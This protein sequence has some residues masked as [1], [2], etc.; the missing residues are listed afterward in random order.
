MFVCPPV[1]QPKLSCI[2]VHYCTSLCTIERLNVIKSRLFCKH[3]WAWRVKDAQSCNIHIL[4]KFHLLVSC[5][6][7]GLF[8][9]QWG[10]IQ[11]QYP[12]PLSD[13]YLISSL[14]LL[15][16]LPFDT[17]LTYHFL[18]PHCKILFLPDT[19]RE[20]PWKRKKF[21]Q[22]LWLQYVKKISAASWNIMTSHK[23]MISGQ[24]SGWWL[25]NCT[26]RTLTS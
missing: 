17:R 12:G 24:H 16:R 5:R 4:F 23:I 9:R 10:W 13:I 22:F 8:L 7:H 25:I 1:N 20:W 3:Y 2:N 26:M 19:N 15:D 21:I 14:C 11:W 6:G 18:S